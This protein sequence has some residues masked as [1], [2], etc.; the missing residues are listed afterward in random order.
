MRDVKNAQQ[1]VFRLHG[2]HDM[3]PSIQDIIGY[4][5][6]RPPLLKWTPIVPTQFLNLAG[7]QRNLPR[8]NATIQHLLEWLA[9][10]VR[11][12]RRRRQNFSDE[13]CDRQ[14]LPWILL[15]VVRAQVVGATL[16]GSDNHC[17]SR[18]IRTD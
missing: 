13:V 7:G 14:Q 15:V 3:M 18:T 11:V 12:F 2:D 10:Q 16:N 4:C 5:A 9:I 6:V 8:R 17:W 1:L